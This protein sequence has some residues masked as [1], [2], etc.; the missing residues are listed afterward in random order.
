VDVRSQCLYLLSFT[1][2]GTEKSKILVD[3]LSDV[4]FEVGPTSW[5]K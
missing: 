1:L 3:L 5:S 2:Y 4:L